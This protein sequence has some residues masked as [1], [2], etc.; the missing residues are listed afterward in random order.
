MSTIVVTGR[1]G[2]IGNLLTER[3]KQKHKVVSIVRSRK[4]LFD[5]NSETIIEKDVKFISA[6]DICSYSPDIFIH[7]AAVIYSGNNNQYIDN[8]EMAKNVCNICNVLDLPLVFSSTINVVGLNSKEDQYVNSKLK[9]EELVSELCKTYSIVR[10]PLVIGRD[11]PLVKGIENILIKWR[12]LLFL[13][14][15]KGRIQPVPVEALIKYLGELIDGTE[16]LRQDI[17]IVGKYIYSYREIWGNV[18][19]HLGIRCIRI[20]I[21]ELL[22]TAVMRVGNLVGINTKINIEQI[23]GLDIDKL[24]DIEDDDTNVM[25]VDNKSISL[26]DYHGR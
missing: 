22:L 21:P 26:F 11:S 14:K 4:E 3:L 23:K 5:Y 2:F 24:I 19:T 16:R 7:F 13:G 9:S 15:Q 25:I 6:D 12:L 18:A 1:N 20:V 8:V 17:N 10:F